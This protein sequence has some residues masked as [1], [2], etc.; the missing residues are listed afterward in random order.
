METV[1]GMTDLQIKL[2]TAMGQILVACAVGVIAYRQWRTAQAQSE[3]A[4]RKLRA[5]LFDRRFA[6]YREMTDLAH[7]VMYT[8]SGGPRERS[9]AGTH[10]VDEL[11]RVAQEMVWLFD[12]DVA[13]YVKEHIAGVALTLLFAHI[14][15]VACTDEERGEE[16]TIEASVLHRDLYNNLVRATAIMGPYLKLEH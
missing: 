8:E 4:R 15:L 1:L 16:L 13:N 3:T 10:T 11:E 2:F 7:A 5:D 12:H 6:A 14:D 9:A